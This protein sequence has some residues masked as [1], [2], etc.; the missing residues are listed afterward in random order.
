VYPPRHRPGPEAPAVQCNA[1]QCH[2]L[3]FSSLSVASCQ[4]LC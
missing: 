2:G 3:A 4:A 1:T